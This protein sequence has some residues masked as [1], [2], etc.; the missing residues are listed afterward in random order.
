MPT[1]THTPRTIYRPV[2]FTGLALLVLR[3]DGLPGG[4][5]FRLELASDLQDLVVLETLE[6]MDGLQ[7]PEIGFRILHRRGL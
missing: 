6:D 2:L 1:R 7:P 3:E 4:A 5:P